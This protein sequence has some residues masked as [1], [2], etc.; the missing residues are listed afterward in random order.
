MQ[1]V[2]LSY[3]TNPQLE[4]ALVMLIVPF[5]VN[6]SASVFTGFQ[7]NH[8]DF[9]RR[10]VSLPPPLQSVMF[11]VVDSL[12][13]RKLKTLKSLDDSCDSSVKKADWEDS[14][15]SRVRKTDNSRLKS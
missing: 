12:T 5:V 10:L 14:E 1:E 7:F 3:I 2:L 13:M 9:N 4:L 6:V 11:W 15:E 8:Q